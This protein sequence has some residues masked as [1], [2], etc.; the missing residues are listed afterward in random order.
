MRETY[1][2]LLYKKGNYDDTELEMGALEGTPNDPR[3]VAN[4]RP[5]ALICCDAKIL[6][7]YTASQLKVY[8]KSV[9]SFTQSAFVPSR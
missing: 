4:Y 6:S 5:I 3:N 9:V 1:Y 8:T 2:K 7:A